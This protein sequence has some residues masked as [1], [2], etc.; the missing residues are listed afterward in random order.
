MA[1]EKRIWNLRLNL[2]DFNS[3]YLKARNDSD[4]LSFFLGFHLGCMGGILSESDSKQFE[5]GFGI[6]IGMFRHAEWLSKINS[7]NANRSVDAR[8][9]KYGT[10]Q[11]IP[12]DRS[13]DR[14]S[15][16][17]ATTERTPEPNE[18]TMNPTNEGTKERRSRFVPPTLDELTAYANEI[19]FR[20][21]AKWM[22]HYA[23]NGWMVGKNKMKDWKACVRNWNLNPI[24]RS[25]S[26][27][28]QPKL[29]GFTPEYME[30]GRIVRNDGLDF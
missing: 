29:T 12:S 30:Q 24:Q 22:N 11:P 28:P 3:E 7:E 25:G 17:R 19:G 26:Q 6:G 27:K 13:S 5:A 4:R 23:S 21:V 1:E 15:D 10:A 18:L 20:D 9:G 2:D 14:S 8:R 16:H